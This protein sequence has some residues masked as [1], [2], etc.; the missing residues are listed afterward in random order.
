MRRSYTPRSI[1]RTRLGIEEDGPP[2]YSCL[3]GAGAFLST[4]TDL[5][6]LGSAMLK[7]GLLKAET[8]TASPDSHAPRLWSVHDIRARLDGRQRPARGRAGTDGQSPGQSQG[9]YRLAPDVPG[10]RSR[11]CRRRQHDG[12]QQ[13]STPSR[14]RSPTRSPDSRIAATIRGNE[15]Y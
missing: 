5:V 11:G 10:S 6:R 14:Y 15:R 2:D 12:C 3:A 7:P 8:I 4:P 1:L 13:A 9:R